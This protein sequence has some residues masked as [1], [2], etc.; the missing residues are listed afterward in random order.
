MSV[1]FRAQKM[2]KAYGNDEVLKAIDIE[3]LEGE[4]IGIV[5]DNGCG[6]S[7]LLEILA[8][9]LQPSKGNYT[10]YRDASIAYMPQVSQ[11]EWDEE[12][13]SGGERTKKHVQEALYQKHH[14]LILDEPTN[15]MDL[16]VRETL[17][18]VLESYQGTLLLIT[19]DTYMMKRLCT[20]LL[21]F[22]NK[23]IKRFEG[24][25]EAYEQKQMEPIK[26]KSSNCEQSQL[27][28][29]EH[30]LAYLIGY[31]SQVKQEDP[32]YQELE[33]R[34]KACLVKKQQLIAVS[35]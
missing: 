6:K 29:I 34:Y 16:H 22:E 35:K 1:L 20:R 8:G 30:E 25:L 19:H 33:Q 10:W 23:V 14:I 4:K 32:Q 9:K 11:I 18:Q 12:T 27:L 21:V 13:L 31:L 5:G 26:K 7:T 3:I 2:S 17:E 28:C 15:H 24:D